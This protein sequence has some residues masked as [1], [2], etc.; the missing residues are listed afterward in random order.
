MA[1]KIVLFYPRH[2]TGWQA[3]PRVSLP[4][5]FLCIAT[6]LDHAGYEV[7]IIDQRI[8][9]KWRSILTGEL[10]QNPLCV[11]I[12]SKTGPQ[13]K[14]ALE[15]SRIVREYGDIPIVWGGAHPS[16]LPEQTLKNECIDIVIQGEG[17]ETFLELAQ[18]MEEERPPDHVKGIW[19]KKNDR[20]IHTGDR[21]FL[22]LNQQPFI[23]LKFI[24][25][26]KYLRTMFDT[27]HLS[28]FSSRG[29]SN[30]CAF[31]YQNVFNRRTWRPMDPDMVVQ[32]I[33]HFVRAYNI[34][35]ITFSDINFFTD[36]GR[37][38]SILEGIIKENLNVVISK[39]NVCVDTLS[40]INRDDLALL[41]KAGCRRLTIGVESGSKKIQALLKKPINL[42]RLLEINRDLNRF[43][44][45]PVYFFM[46]GIPTETKEDLKETVSLAARL[47]KDNPNSVR[48]FNIFTPL[49]GTELFDIAV[50]Y[51]LR[52][53]ECLEDW[54]PF[55]Y[56][57]LTQGAPWLSEEMRRIVEMLDFCA[58]F[59]GK[60]PFLQ[61]YE[62]TNPL[63]PLLCN[64]YAP[65][66]RKR[67]KYFWGQFP[68]E[69]KL[70]KLFGLYAKQD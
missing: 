39:I 21:P 31:C 40:K 19:F 48:T 53:P 57:N 4:I 3:Q 17:E 56:R 33:K 1:K 37:A 47:L 14:H 42:P 50:K 38:R 9:P 32:R 7:K 44:I 62:K 26:Q 24:E 60:R 65:L 51:G 15:A 25:P 43:P 13:I 49:P 68:V 27:G 29:C 67:V 12:S 55:N 8:E 59:T 23:S 5:S 46:M 58:F 69:I 20:M 30:P 63:V 64:I 6:L 70:A 45:V 10:R 54:I 18:A 35:G 61:P 36:I 16:L 2:I 34:R 52:S 28:F 41:E 66:A 22:N 11:G